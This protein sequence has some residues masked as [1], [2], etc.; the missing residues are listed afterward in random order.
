M[1]GKFVFC[2]S[3]TKSW[4]AFYAD[5]GIRDRLCF[6]DMDVDDNTS[7]PFV[8]VKGNIVIF[9]MHIWTADFNTWKNT[10]PLY[11]NRNLLTR[12]YEADGDALWNKALTRS[13]SVL[14]TNKVSGHSWA[15]VGATPFAKRKA[16]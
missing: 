2:L 6:S 9:N 1:K 12:V 3:G 10:L 5:S 13:A 16:V 7:N 11:F 14:A 4:K 8:P 15:K